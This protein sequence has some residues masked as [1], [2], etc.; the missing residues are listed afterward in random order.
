MA[1]R[2]R[3][4]RPCNARPP[5]AAP[6]TPPRHT[7]LFRLND[8]PGSVNDGFN[9]G[10]VH[11]PKILRPV[12]LAGLAMCSSLAA[13]A[14]DLTET[15]LRWLKGAWP[16]IT[17]AEQAKIPL[18]IVVQPQA[19]AGNAPLALG[20]VDGRC[21]LVLSMRGNPEAEATLQRI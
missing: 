1:V 13:R 14:A 17:Y 7:P 18:D 21:K 4:Q 11:V 8:A 9:Q 6:H 2:R 15:E 12:L 5:R 3:R 19:T 16:V 20:F 10:A